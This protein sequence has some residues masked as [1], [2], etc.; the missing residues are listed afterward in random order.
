MSA[1][2]S[3]SLIP[4]CRAVLMVALLLL[5]ACTVAACTTVRDDLGRSQSA[6]Y[7]ALPSAAKA[8]GD[9][10]RLVGVQLLTVGS[11]RQRSASLFDEL[12][13]GHS[14]AQRVCV[15]AFEGNFTQV[16]VSKPLGQP[17]GHLVVVVLTSPANRLI[18]SVIGSHLPLGFGHSHIG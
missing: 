1:P 9:H 12:H 7:L 10:H 11:L 3:S 17:A 16:S 6:C 14:S 18:G 5:G 8:A 13:L 2:R 4:P 15:F